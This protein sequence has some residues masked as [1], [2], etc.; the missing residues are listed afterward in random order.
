MTFAL[1][2]CPPNRIEEAFV[3]MEQEIENMPGSPS[4]EAFSRQYL[5]YI[6]NYYMSGNFGSQATGY[7][8][9]FYNTMDEGQMTNN[10]SEGQNN[11]IATRVG[12]KHPGFYEF[13][14]TI[15][16]EAENSRTKVEQYELGKVLEQQDRK[17][18]SLQ[19][20]RVDLKILLEAEPNGIG[21]RG[22]LRSQGRA[23]HH[24]K[25]IRGQDQ[26][27]LL[28]GVLVSVTD[29]DADDISSRG[30]DDISGRGRGARTRGRGAGRARGA[31]GVR[32]RGAAPRY[33]NCPDCGA[34]LRSTYIYTHRRLHCHGAV[35]EDEEEDYNDED[36]ALDEGEVEEVAEESDDPE[37]DLEA[38]LQ[39]IVELDQS[40]LGHRVSLG[41]RVTEE[42]EDETRNLMQRFEALCHRRVRHRSEEDEDDSSTPTQ[43]QRTEVEGQLH[44]LA[45]TSPVPSEPTEL[46][47]PT[48]PAASSE[49]RRPIPSEPTEP[50]E[51]TEL[52]E[53]PEPTEAVASSAELSF[54]DFTISAGTSRL[55]RILSIGSPEGGR[56]QDLE[57]SLTGTV[58]RL[59][60][61][62]QVIMIHT[63][64][65]TL[66]WPS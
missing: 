62:G 60:G 50:E 8:W 2:L 45:D 64:R 5:Q 31:R 13:C 23:N 14:Q 44:R 51:P 29:G 37:A 40:I 46:P 3:L 56:I 16:K 41:G 17:A 58:Y 42:E 39:D 18:M 12:K 20:T 59:E 15:Q 26:G 30:Q 52:P 6:R 22:Y 38:V 11:R 48:E 27:Q 53:L 28:R 19:K 55:L 57:G 35:A 66:G 1:P 33:R 47:E 61:V 49:D 21:L 54:I 63:L 34:H 32:G 25:K 24:Q 7:E 9:N 10:P 65:G 43:R 4:V 36:N